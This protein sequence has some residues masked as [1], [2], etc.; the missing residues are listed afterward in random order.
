M[1]PLSEHAATKKEIEWCNKMRA[2]MRQKPTTLTLFC[3][4]DIHVLSTKEVNS[5]VKKCGS[6]PQPI[7]G[8]DSLGRADGG[9]F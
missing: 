5:Q 6:M 3:N 1:S 4:G 7:Q 8:I 9:D 2:L